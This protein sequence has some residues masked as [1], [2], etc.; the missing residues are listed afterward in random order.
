[1]KNLRTILF[2]SFIGASLGQGLTLEIKQNEAYANLTAE[3]RSAKMAKHVE[4]LHAVG[5]EILK[6]DDS[7][8]ESELDLISFDILAETYFMM[9]SSVGT[10]TQTASKYFFTSTTQGTMMTGVGCPADKC[11]ETVYDRTTS[12]SAKYGGNCEFGR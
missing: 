7:D 8:N 6:D 1:M 11:S 2:S 4:Y 9:E 5:Q 3:E 10:P 12:T